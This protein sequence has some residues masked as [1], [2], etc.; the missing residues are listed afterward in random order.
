ME[1]H[2][3]EG[4][5]MAGRYGFPW[6]SC[7]ARWMPWF[8]HSCAGAGNQCGAGPDLLGAKREFGFTVSAWN[9]GP[10]GSH[11]CL[12]AVAAVGARWLPLAGT[13]APRR[14]VSQTGRG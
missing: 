10:G 8:L 3:P 1:A 14:R 12:D 4:T 7:P 5:R 11:A 9:F 13:T 6:L 2:F